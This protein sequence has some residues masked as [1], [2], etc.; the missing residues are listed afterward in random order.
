MNP[1]TLAAF[2]SLLHGLRRIRS[3]LNLWTMHAFFRALTRLPAR[4]LTAPDS[5]LERAGFMLRRR[6]ES[7]WSLLRSDWWA[8]EERTGVEKRR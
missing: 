7:E 3:R 4:N 5:Y 8:S 6:T 2:E 1:A